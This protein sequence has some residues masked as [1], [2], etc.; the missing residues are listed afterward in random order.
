MKLIYKRIKFEKQIQF[1]NKSTIKIKADI[2]QAKILALW[3]F[4]INTLLMVKEKEKKRDDC[5]Y[6]KL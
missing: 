4:E 2:S 1:Y 5:I 3:R 6:V